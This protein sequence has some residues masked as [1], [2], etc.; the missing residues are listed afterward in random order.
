M[1]LF[2]VIRQSAPLL[3][4]WLRNGMNNAGATG[5]VPHV[6]NSKVYIHELVD[7]IGHNRAAY[8]HHMTANWG[9]TAREER[10]MLCFGVWATVGSTGRW[11]QTVNLWELDG[12]RG[13]AANFRHEFSHTTLQDPSLEGWWA[14]A[15]TLRSGGLDRLRGLG[16]DRS[17]AAALAAA[18]AISPFCFFS[19]VSLHDYLRVLKMDGGHRFSNSLGI[20]N[21]EWFVAFSIVAFSPLLILNAGFDIKC[22][23]LRR[24]GDLAAPEAGRGADVTEPYLGERSCR[25]RQG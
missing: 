3:R 8:M 18:V 4:S 19:T 2:F 21:I 9:S 15:A 22:A 5:T 20:G 16:L 25:S 24:C 14:Q 13:M 12:W 11:P 10:N 1:G 7:V 6:A 23:V 17:Y